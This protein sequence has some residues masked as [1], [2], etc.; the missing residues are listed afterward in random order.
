MPLIALNGFPHSGGHGIQG[1]IGN[2]ISEAAISFVPL[3]D[4][5]IFPF[6]H[7]APLF[8]L[9]PIVIV[10]IKPRPLWGVFSETFLATSIKM[11]KGSDSST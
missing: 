6:E 5:G 3:N 8:R 9:L 10:I 4:A 1:I 2:Q 11:G 7:K